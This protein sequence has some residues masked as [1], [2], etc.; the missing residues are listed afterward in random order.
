VVPLTVHPDCYLNH[1]IHPKHL[2]WST[3]KSSIKQKHTGL[4]HRMLKITKENAPKKKRK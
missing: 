2:C 3:G 4:N 1:T